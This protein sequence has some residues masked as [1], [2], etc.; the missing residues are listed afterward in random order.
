MRDAPP[1]SAPHLGSSAWTGRPRWGLTRREV[2]LAALGALAISVVMNWPLPLHLT[3]TIPKDLGDPLP[4][5]WQVAWGG[6]ALGSQPLDNE[7]LDLVEA[8]DFARQ[9][10][11]SG[12][13]VLL[14]VKAADLD[15]QLHRRRMVRLRGE[16]SGYLDATGRP[17]SEATIPS[18]SGS[19]SAGFTFGFLATSIG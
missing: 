7:P 19:S 3:D 12:R 11:Q 8:R 9:L 10:G 6:H 4:Q 15:D 1:R 18:T 13:Q 14:L 16:P 17:R 2:L 5:A